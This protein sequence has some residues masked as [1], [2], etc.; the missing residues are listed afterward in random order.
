MD[1]IPI[2][3]MEETREYQK[4]LEELAEECTCDGDRPCAGLMAGGFC[5]DL[6]WDEDDD[7]C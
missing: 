5:D 4:W 1:F 7:E 2:T 6:H 3:P